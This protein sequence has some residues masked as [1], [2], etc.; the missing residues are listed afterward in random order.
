MAKL[1][2]GQKEN[3]GMQHRPPRNPTGGVKT[4]IVIRHK[5]PV[6]ESN[7][8]AAKRAAQAMTNLNP[9]ASYSQK[10]EHQVTL[11]QTHSTGHLSNKHSGVILRGSGAPIEKIIPAAQTVEQ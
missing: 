7:A 1:R 11:Q 4:P 8:E 2:K 6:K 10:N 9:G 5:P 3:Y